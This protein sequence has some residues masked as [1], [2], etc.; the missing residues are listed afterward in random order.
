VGLRLRCT[1]WNSWSNFV[2]INIGVLS[3]SMTVH[4][5]IFGLRKI[6]VL[7]S[8]ALK[9]VDKLVDLLNCDLA[10]VC[11]VKNFEYLLILLLIQIEL[12]ILRVTKS[13]QYIWSTYG[14]GARIGSFFVLIGYLVGFGGWINHIAG[15]KLLLILFFIHFYFQY[16]L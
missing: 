8:G 9:L 16:L 2:I 15:K 3:L 4:L 12:I 13:I 5:I 14:F 11:F 1:T 10:R 6:D 7:G